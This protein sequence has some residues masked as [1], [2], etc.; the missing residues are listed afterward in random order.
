MLLASCLRSAHAR[1]GEALLGF[2]DQLVKLQDLKANSAPRQLNINGSSMGVLTL[3]TQLDVAAA[4]D[5]FHS[6]CRQRGGLQVPPALANKLGPARTAFD[7]TFRQEGSTEGVLACIDSGHPLSL[8][9]LTER[10][11]ALRDSGDLA[12]L[13]ELRYVFARRSGTTTTLLV[14]WTDGSA[15]LLKMF[16]P[17][18]DAPGRDPENVPRPEGSRRVLSATEHGAPYHVTLY[19]AGSRSSAALLNWYSHALEASG[20]QLAPGSSAGSLRA[21]RQGR[22][23]VVAC[24]S[25][26]D[27]GAVATIAELD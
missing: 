22:H 3:S 18:G 23:V 11:T 10:L 13:G 21:Q 15:P 24:S 9:Q 19:K 12:A 5:R 26:K 25:A 14:F 8:E 1:L 17:A 4:L 2:G 20:W 7:A 6:L 16:P 27:G